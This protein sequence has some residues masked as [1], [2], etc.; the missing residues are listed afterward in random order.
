[1]EGHI[2]RGDGRLHPRIDENEPPAGLTADEWRAICEGDSIES[3][4]KM[5]R[6]LGVPDSETRLI[7]LAVIEDEAHR[8]ELLALLDDNSGTQ[9]G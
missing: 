4:V 9:A 7:G 5:S 3:L 8:R 1:M 2:D 6:V